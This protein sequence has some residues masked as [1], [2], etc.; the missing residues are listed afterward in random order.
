MEHRPVAS[1]QSHQAMQQR[2]AIATQEK[3][4]YTQLRVWACHGIIT[5]RLASSRDS[6]SAGL[7]LSTKKGARPRK[8]AALSWQRSPRLF[9]VTFVLY[10][11]CYLLLGSPMKTF[12]SRTFISSGTKR[13]L[14]GQFSITTIWRHHS[15]DRLQAP[16]ALQ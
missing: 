5:V 4:G 7:R 16:A 13:C 6:L 10:I 12:S 3:L 11:Y 9:N 2:N 14:S 15:E 8:L 1:R